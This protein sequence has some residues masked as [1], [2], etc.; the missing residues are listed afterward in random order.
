MQNNQYVMKAQ[1]EFEKIK[2][3]FDKMKAEIKSSIADQKIDQNTQ[4]WQDSME[5]AIKDT[6]AT[7]SAYSQ[8]GKDTA[9]DLQTSLNTAMEDLK[10]KLNLRK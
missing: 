1:A 2:A 10:K 7:L 6:Q 5:K 3:N 9:E 4:E 8:A